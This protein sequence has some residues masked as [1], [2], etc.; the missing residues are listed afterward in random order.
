[1][2]KKDRN[3]RVP[4]PIEYVGENGRGPNIAPEKIEAWKNN[5]YN[6]GVLYCYNN[7]DVLELY[8]VE[9]ADKIGLVFSDKNDV[10][11]H[12]DKKYYWRKVI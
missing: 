11:Y 9:D 1:M 2:A 8:L 12:D 7:M 10:A 5:E 4:T 3:D 6:C